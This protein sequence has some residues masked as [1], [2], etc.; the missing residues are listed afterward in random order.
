[1]H[2]YNEYIHADACIDPAGEDLPAQRF[3]EMMDR[4]IK[5]Q[6]MREDE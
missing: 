4:V 6:A 1:M 3:K 5:I 2:M